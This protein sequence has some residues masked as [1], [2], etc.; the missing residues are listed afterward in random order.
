MTATPLNDNHE[1]VVLACDGIWDVL[2][3]QEVI[4]FI[5]PKLAEGL[6]P[7]VVRYRIFKQIYQQNFCL[8]I[9]ERLF[10]G[11]RSCASCLELLAADKTWA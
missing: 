9:C 11:G 4:D 6:S 3:S 7:D 1:F 8:D 2:T 10:H 5:R